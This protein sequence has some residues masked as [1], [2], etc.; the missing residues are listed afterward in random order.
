MNISSISLLYYLFTF[1]AEGE[2]NLSPDLLF[3]SEHDEVVSEIDVSEE[4]SLQQMDN[5]K[6]SI[7]SKLSGPASMHQRLLKHLNY[8]A[9]QTHAIDY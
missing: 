3:C 5:L 7:I 8:E 9:A 2:E 1:I 4:E 6:I